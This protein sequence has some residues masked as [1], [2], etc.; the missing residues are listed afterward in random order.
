[1]YEIKASATAFDTKE[2]FVGRSIVCFC[3]NNLAIF[4]N[5]IILASCCTV[6]TGSKYFLFDLVDT[7]F[8]SALHGKCT[9]RTSL[10]TVTTGFAVAVNPFAFTIADN[11]LETT[12]HSCNSTSAYNLVTGV[13]T[14]VTEDTKAWV[15]GKEFVTVINFSTLFLTCVTGSIQTI[16]IRIVLKFTVT[17]SRAGETLDIVVRKQ[18]IQCFTS[19]INDCI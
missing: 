13:D 5:K 10:N 14:S 1:M 11:G 17:I 3:I 19:G 9:C 7:I 2:T 16:L 4:D 12:I 6:R 18:K 15:I 8:L